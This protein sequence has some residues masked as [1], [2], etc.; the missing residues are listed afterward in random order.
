MNKKQI[1]TLRAYG[2]NDD[3]TSQVLIDSAKDMVDRMIREGELDEI[4]RY[5]AVD[6]Y[7]DGFDRTYNKIIGNHRNATLTDML[8][9]ENETI[10]RHAKGILKQFDKLSL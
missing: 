10:K 6:H 1:E 8:F 2:Q 5:E 9:H 3:Y 4:D 7:I